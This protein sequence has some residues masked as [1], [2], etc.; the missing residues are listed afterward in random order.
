MANEVKDKRSARAHVRVLDIAL[1]LL[2]VFSAL[3]VWQKGNLA[4]V[5]ESD[6]TQTV[7]SVTFRINNV[8]YD[9]AE[10]LHT[11]SALYMDAN[12]TKAEIGTLSDEPTVL[13]R[14]EEIQDDEGIIEVIKPQDAPY[15]TVD[16]NGVFTCRG[17]LREGVL[18][19]GDRAICVGESVTVYT[20]RG[21]FLFEVL[22]IAENL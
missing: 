2:I 16:V 4:Y 3:A 18:L 10:I 22:T 21:S 5:F 20:D 17:V 6:H 19:I 11:G 14:V 8:R 15:R 1:V 12:G 9:A 7:Y 13:P